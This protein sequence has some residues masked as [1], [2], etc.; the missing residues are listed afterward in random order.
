ME[1]AKP[2]SGEPWPDHGSGPSTLAAQAGEPAGEAGAGAGQGNQPKSGF[3]EMLREL[4]SIVQQLETGEL[5]LERALELF[6][7]G[8]ELARSCRQW[9]D[10]MER[11]VEWLLAD[12]DGRV[13]S[14]AASN[15]L[16][17]ADGP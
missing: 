1:A 10:T 2:K 4:E 15:L 5:G 9:L 3:E 8:V 13:R 12:A 17:E 11:R 14:V 16:E 7:R 6:Q